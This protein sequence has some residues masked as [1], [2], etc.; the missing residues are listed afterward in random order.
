MQQLAEVRLKG[1]KGQGGEVGRR[2]LAT[3]G[4]QAAQQVHHL[5]NGRLAQDQTDVLTFR[6]IITTQ[7]EIN[8]N[9]LSTGQQF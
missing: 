5:H 9:Y 7:C 2:V 3:E 6:A 1:F 4:G 8:L